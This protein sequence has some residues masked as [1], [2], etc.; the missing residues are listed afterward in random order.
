M[1]TSEVNNLAAERESTFVSSVGEADSK[2]Q[3]LRDAKGGATGDRYRE[4]HPNDSYRILQ[5][6]SIISYLIIQ[7][8]VLTWFNMVWRCSSLVNLNVRYTNT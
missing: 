2:E 3:G 4:I 7:W 6:D 1:E 8:C 5:G